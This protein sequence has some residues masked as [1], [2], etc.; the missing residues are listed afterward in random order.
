MQ[1]APNMKTKTEAGE[2]PEADPASGPVRCPP[3]EA[4]AR[5]SRN[6]GRFRMFV[7]FLGALSLVFL[8]PLLRLFFAATG[9]E[10]LSYIL[11]I[12]FVFGYLIHIRRDQ[13]PVD[14]RRSLLGCGVLLAIGLFALALAFSSP[15]LSTKA[16]PSDHLAL[17]IFAF[18]CF[19]VSGGFVFLGRQWMRSLVFPFAFLIFLVP[20]PNEAIDGLERASQIASADAADILFTLSG[21]PILRDGMVFQLPGMVIQVAQECSGIRSS[22]VLFITSLV[23]AHLFLSRAWTR[24]VLV[25]FVIPLGILRNGL[26]ILMIG[27][28]CVHYGPAMINSVIHRRGGPFFFALSLIPLFLLLLWLRKFESRRRDGRAAGPEPSRSAS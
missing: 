18:V 2:L 19:V 22:L 28:L 1:N 11:L 14:S 21:T 10:V 7:F 25:A 12:P 20:L 17:T 24:I 15:H 27:L 5:Q 16:N 8:A 13:L 4:I 3:T 6:S 9:S 23:A 26:R